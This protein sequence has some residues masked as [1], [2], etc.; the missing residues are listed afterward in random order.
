MVKKMSANEAGAKA[1]QAIQAMSGGVGLVAATGILSE[2]FSKM[3]GNNE[4]KGLKIVLTTMLEHYDAKTYKLQ[5]DL[6]QQKKS[7]DD[8]RDQEYQARA[9]NLVL[10]E[11]IDD[12][13][14]QLKEFKTKKKKK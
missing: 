5:E 9:E 11:H 12:L 4:E 1:D 8:L 14:D 13:K 3:F 6:R 7:Y 2:V 10:Q